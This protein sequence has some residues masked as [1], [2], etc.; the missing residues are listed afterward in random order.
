MFATKES[1]PVTVIPS[2]DHI[3]AL[4]VKLELHY[5]LI[6]SCVYIPPNPPLFMTSSPICRTYCIYILQCYSGW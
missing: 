3:E 1:I 2:P 5:P 6:F 4:T